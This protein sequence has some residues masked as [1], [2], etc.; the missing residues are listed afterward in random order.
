MFT[1]DPVTNNKDSI[2]IEAIYGLGELIVSGRMTPDHYE[3]SKNNFS[4]IKKII[5][6]Q[7]KQLIKGKKGNKLISIARSYQQTQ[8]L[9][10]EKIIQL[11]KIGKLIE[12]HYFFPQDIEW[13]YKDS[14][15]YI[16][17]TRPVTT[18]KTQKG[19]VLV[20]EMTN[21]DFVPG[22]KRAVAVITDK[23]GRTS[24]AA[25]VS[26]ELGIACVVG[27]ENATKKLHDGMVVTVDGAKGIVYKGQ[28]IFGKKILTSEISSDKVEKHY[29]TATKLYVNLAEPNLAFK[30]A[31]QNV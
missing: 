18:L 5:A 17:Q 19:D 6:K 24:H 23:G 13:A 9:A 20:T 14:T 30:V 2:V 16:V 1:I 15:I 3:I 8:K 10:D 21:P 28:I 27:T 22:M 11:A 4:P 26:R 7:D 25:I 29:K 12:K 31:S